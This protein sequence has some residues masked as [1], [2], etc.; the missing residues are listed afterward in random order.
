MTSVMLTCVTL[1]Q[2][3]KIRTLLFTSWQRGSC[4]SY[5]PYWATVR[6]GPAPVLSAQKQ[7]ALLEGVRV[8]LQM[9]PC[10]H[11]R[12]SLSFLLMASHDLPFV[13]RLQAHSHFH[14]LI[15]LSLFQRGRHKRK[16]P[17]EGDQPGQPRN[18]TECREAKPLFFQWASCG[19][20]QIRGNREG[21]PADWKSEWVQ[22][23]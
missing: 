18:A 2:L 13:L 4:L 23:G 21:R 10:E 8:S 11:V 20:S 5:L 12:M 6:E 1:D 19:E 14:I 16:L 3:L 22:G 15:F 9:H 7:S 17:K